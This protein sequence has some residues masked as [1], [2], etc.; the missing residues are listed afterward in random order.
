MSEVHEEANA[1]DDGEPVQLSQCRNDVEKAPK[2]SG[3][4]RFEDAAVG[5]RST[6]AVRQGGSCSSPTGLG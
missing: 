1:V 4:R 5:L 3:Q 6:T 2:R